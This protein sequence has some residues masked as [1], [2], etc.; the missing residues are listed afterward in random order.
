M[1]EN[2]EQQRLGQPER[3][4]ILEG[5]SREA[6]DKIAE[7]VTKQVTEEIMSKINP[8]FDQMQAEIGGL[9]ED[10]EQKG[11]ENER[12]RKKIDLLEAQQAAA[13]STGDRV[14]DQASSESAAESRMGNTSAGEAPVRAERGTDEWFDQF[15]DGLD[16]AWTASW[17]NRSIGNAEES[18]PRPETTE[19]HQAPTNEQIKA[20]EAQSKRDS[21][22]EMY[23]AGGVYPNDKELD[24]I[25][26]YLRGD[27]NQLT[28]VSKERAE[29]IVMSMQATGDI[30]PQQAKQLWQTIA[31]KEENWRDPLNSG[32]IICQQVASAEQ[33]ESGDMPLNGGAL[34]KWQ[35][36]TREQATPL[37]W[38]DTIKAKIR[39]WHNR[40]QEAKRTDDTERS[41]E[42]NSRRYLAATLVGSIALAAAL[43][44]TGGAGIATAEAANTNNG[45]PAATAVSESSG[46]QL[47]DQGL[48][49]EAM[50]QSRAEIQ[51]NKAEQI[52]VRNYN[53]DNVPDITYRKWGVQ[54]ADGT[55]DTNAKKTST[56]FSTPLDISS[57]SSIYNGYM[58]SCESDPE[59]L[60]LTA[61]STFSPEEVQQLGLNQ[62]ANVLANDL[63][64][65]KQLRVDVLNKVA[66]KLSHLQ[67]TQLAEGRYDNSGNARNNDGDWR[68]TYSTI[69]VG[70]EGK[71]VVDFGE[72]EHQVLVDWTCCNIIGLRASNT[73]HDSSTNL[74]NVPSTDTSNPNNPGGNGNPNNPG[75]HD[76]PGTNNP[77]D[78]G[79]PNNPGDDG[80]PNNP[81]DNGNP[82]NPGDD[83]DHDKPGSNNPDDDNNHHDDKQ[84]EPKKTDKMQGESADQDETA[85]EDEETNSQT[86]S[87][88]AT[89]IL[90]DKHESNDQ[91]TEQAPVKSETVKT[92]TGATVVGSGGNKHTEDGGKTADS[93]TVDHSDDSSL[94]D[95]EAAQDKASQAAGEDEITKKPANA[96]QETVRDGDKL[97]VSGV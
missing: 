60:A 93:V 64:A 75:D 80:N 25:R 51:A 45:T 46:D 94:I 55:W 65:N 16:T 54:R 26:A 97:P 76:N 24:S 32:D 41:Q 11:K 87:A 59:Q 69:Y 88:G 67:M 50:Q 19:V 90:G 78:D 37:G 14:V 48:T 35:R 71:Q 66:Q 49:A 1:T 91:P 30:N 34:R 92:T 77:G 83:G 33:T 13:S 9:K 70:P 18:A 81:G 17:S 8:L 23:K 28:R 47:V 3:G 42:R 62:D 21:L 74:V 40:R 52:Q 6:Y 79:N 2:G 96:S 12:L 73:S 58:D 89:E 15:T 44:G 27:T 61:L 20:S 56:S 72:G 57:P 39:D 85:R 63:I 84:T 36:S 43:V 95:H 31:P 22:R 29:Q 5:V 86:P 7:A 38:I 53:I 68:I 4:D 82:N 10:N